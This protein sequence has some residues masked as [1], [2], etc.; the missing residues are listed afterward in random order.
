MYARCLNRGLV[1]VA[2][3]DKLVNFV[4]KANE[5]SQV[6]ALMAI[7]VFCTESGH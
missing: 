4:G 6:R 2:K 5:C 7:S 3:M 1:R